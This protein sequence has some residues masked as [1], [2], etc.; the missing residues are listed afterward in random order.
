MD[1]TPIHSTLW[2]DLHKEGPSRLVVY[3]PE[4]DLRALIFRQLEQTPYVK[5]LVKRLKKNPYLR[6]ACGYRDRAPC[7]A[8]FSQMKQ[9]IGS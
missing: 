1:L 4:W 7:E 5:D 6:K 8:H 2:T 9:R 3:N